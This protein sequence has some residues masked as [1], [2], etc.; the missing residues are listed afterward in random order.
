M[1]AIQLAKQAG[2]TVISTASSDEKLERL[3]E[4]GLDHGINYAS[5]SFVER[6]RELTDGRG[7]DVIL[8]SVGGY[9]SS[10]F[11]FHGRHGPTALATCQPTSISAPPQDTTPMIAIMPVISAVFLASCAVKWADSQRTWAKR[12]G[13]G[14]CQEL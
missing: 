10:S 1:A 4:F 9:S 2:A 7:V 13:P 11:D 3:A 14:A 8:D 12:W 6:T 5:E